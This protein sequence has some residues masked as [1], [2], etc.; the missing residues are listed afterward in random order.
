MARSKNR[1]AALASRH[2]DEHVDDLA[3]LVDRPIH[4]PPPAGDLHIGLVHL[5]TVTHG[6][7]AGPGG[8]G[9]QRREPLHPPV[10]G[11]VVDLD[12]AFDQEFFDVT[13]GL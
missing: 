1:R 3:E 12:P 13:V 2:L 11:D 5:L 6:V 10:D 4:V 8:V 9:Q 7:A